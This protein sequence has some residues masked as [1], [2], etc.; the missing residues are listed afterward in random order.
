[1]EDLRTIERQRLPL[2]KSRVLLLRVE[3]SCSTLLQVL[4]KYSSLLQVSGTN[5]AELHLL[6][7]LV[8]A[9]RIVKD[10]IAMPEASRPT[11]LVV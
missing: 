7:S 3:N 11:S 9:P 6:A 4:K 8:R 1:M 5:W 2:L 10:Q